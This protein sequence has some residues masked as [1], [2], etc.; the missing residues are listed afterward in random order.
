MFG[1]IYTYIVLFG[2][3]ISIL[4]FIKHRTFLLPILL[5][6]VLLIPKF[7]PVILSDQLAQIEEHLEFQDLSILPNG[8]EVSRDEVMNR[9]CTFAVIFPDYICSFQKIINL[10]IMESYQMIREIVNT[11]A[12][13]IQ[14]SWVDDF[15]STGLIFNLMVFSIMIYL[16]MVIIR[17]VMV[18][19]KMKSKM[20]SLFY[21]KQE[22]LALEATILQLLIDTLFDT[23][24]TIL[25]VFLNV[26]IIKLISIIG[27]YAKSTEIVLKTLQNAQHYEMT[28]LIDLIVV[29]ILLIFLV[30]TMFKFIYY[31]FQILYNLVMQVLMLSILPITDQEDTLTKYIK[32]NIAIC[33]GIV[34]SS[35]VFLLIYVVKDAD[36][37][38]RIA[39]MIVVM[40]MVTKLPSEFE[41]RIG[42]AFQRFGGLNTLRNWYRTAD[43]IHTSMDPMEPK[44]LLATSYYSAKYKASKFLRSK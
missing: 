43:K 22:V 28:G 4:L 37:L 11:Y 27:V 5:V 6:I 34:S 21:D 31:N 30:Y 25:L 14:T 3:I 35:Y 39:G 29:V 7:I 1:D 38:V 20:I 44:G 13:K 32:R 9:S 24:V 16:V 41:E 15:I 2:L 12:F 33:L 42:E 23:P 36:V 18:I 8:K 10:T 26:G 40:I 19:I 17:V